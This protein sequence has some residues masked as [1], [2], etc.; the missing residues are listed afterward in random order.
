MLGPRKRHRN[1]VTRNATGRGRGLS[2]CGP[3]SPT[4]R[5]C[6]RLRGRAERLEQGLQRGVVLDVRQ[7]VEHMLHPP[8]H[9]YPFP[10]GKGHAEF[11]HPS[12]TRW[13]P[14][15]LAETNETLRR[16]QVGDILLGKPLG[17]AADLRV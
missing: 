17:I 6:D 13:L 10:Q 12:P 4:A 15:G 16:L 9:A 11:H 3:L 5:L 1:N 7:R 8:D 14:Y 2:L